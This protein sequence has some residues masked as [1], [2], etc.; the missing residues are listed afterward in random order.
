MKVVEYLALGFG[1]AV[2]AL[3]LVFLTKAEWSSFKQTR[4]KPLRVALAFLSLFIGLFVVWA[5][6]P[7]PP[8]LPVTRYVFKWIALVFV[9]VAMFGYF[10]LYM[11]L[12]TSEWPGL[13]VK[14]PPGEQSP[15]GGALRGQPSVSDQVQGKVLE[16]LRVIGVEPEIS[17]YGL[18]YWYGTMEKIGKGI[19]A[20]LFHG[21]EAEKAKL[22]AEQCRLLD[23]NPKV[24]ALRLRQPD[25]NLTEDAL[26]D[27]LRR[28]DQG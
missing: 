7:S 10:G 22:L 5:F 1:A 21:D 20:G 3:M 9:I 8:V 2:G 24:Y 11:R 15:E 4:W 19:E 17:E 28:K 26:R 18:V 12:A 27:I 16:D 25:Y 23:R 14:Q 6:F 13:P